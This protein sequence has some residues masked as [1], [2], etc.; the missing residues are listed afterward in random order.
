[1][2]HK[3]VRRCLFM[4]LPVYLLGVFIAG[5]FNTNMWPMEFRGL[6][7]LAWCITCVWVALVTAMWYGRE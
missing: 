7:A 3:I 4:L 2:F 5:S 1:M 6:I